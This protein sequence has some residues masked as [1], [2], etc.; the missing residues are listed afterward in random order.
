MYTWI[1]VAGGLFSFIA[2]MGIGAN[3]VAM[4]A[5]GWFKA[6]TIKQAVILASIFETSGALLMGSHVL[7]LSAKG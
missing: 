3:D 7:K 4:Y 5:N 2:A 6:L 1:V